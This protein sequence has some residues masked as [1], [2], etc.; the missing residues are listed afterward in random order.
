[1]TIAALGGWKNVQTVRRY[2]LASGI[3]SANLARSLDF[4]K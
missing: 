3:E 4:F 2:L 1:M